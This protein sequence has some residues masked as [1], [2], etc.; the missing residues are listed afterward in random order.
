MKNNIIVLGV[1]FLVSVV[2][3]TT[4][5]AAL[6]QALSYQPRTQAET[7]AYLYGRIAM[8]LEVKAL[9]QKN[10]SLTYESMNT[11][12]NFVTIETMSAS[13]EKVTDAVLRAE[14][15]TYGKGSATVWFEYGQDEGF[16]DFRTNSV[17]VDSLYGR[18]VR[19]QVRNLEADERYYYRA[20]AM[21]RETKLVTYGETVAFRTEEEDEDE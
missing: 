15:I 14:A 21:D 12:G 1:S 4:P 10:G 6:A 19:T 5:A 13:E 9:L 3:L 18:A 8:L 7:L 17:T 20:A 2:V 11:L 16:L